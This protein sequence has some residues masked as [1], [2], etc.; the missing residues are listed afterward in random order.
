MK[1]SNYFIILLIT[2]FV[3]FQTRAQNI[4]GSLNTAKSAYAANDELT[5]RDNL[6][7]ALIDINNLMGKEILAIM[8]G[9]LGGLATNAAKDNIIG[10]TG[11]AG[12]LVSRTY[13]TDS[14][15]DIDV[16]IANE[17]PMLAM[18]N[19]F[20]GDS[21]LSGIMASQTGQ[22]Q[23]TVSGYKGMIETSDGEDG[24][25]I[26]TIN[27]PINDSLFTF[28]TTG[29]DNENDVIDMAQQL[30]LDKIDAF[31]K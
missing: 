27:V 29:F 1:N 5:A 12:L 30:N 22:K 6:K 3:G 16:T 28:E 20:L 19:A 15:K 13:G 24:P 9:S 26:F 2:L 21:M 23:I 10:D 14:N 7:K 4:E 25:V 11:F 17:S 8:P 31:L 18:V